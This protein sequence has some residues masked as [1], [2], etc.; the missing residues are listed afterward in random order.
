MGGMPGIGIPGIGGMPGIGIPGI[1]C[2]PGM[3]GYIGAPYIG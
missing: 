3:P 1:G 2:I